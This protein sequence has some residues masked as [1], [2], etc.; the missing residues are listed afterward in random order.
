LGEFYY[1]KSY[2]FLLQKIDNQNYDRSLPKLLCRSL[3][4]KLDILT[5]PCL[6]I[7]SLMLFVLNNS[8]NFHTNS[9]VHETNTRYKYQL[10]RSVVNLSCYQRRVYYSGIRI[11]SSWPTAIYNLINVKSHVRAAMQSYPALYSLNYINLLALE[12]GI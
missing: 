12:F 8:N 6:D 7:F 10:Q 4:R 9:S 3:F 5:F 11:F 2:F 1:F